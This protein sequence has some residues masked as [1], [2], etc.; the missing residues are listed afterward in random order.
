M[1]DFDI[2]MDKADEVEIAFYDQQ[3][4]Q[5][6]P[7]PRVLIGV[8]WLKVSDLLEAL[9]RQK[10]EGLD[11]DA[12]GW[13]TAAT[14]RGQDGSSGS[15]GQRRNGDVDAPLGQHG[16]LKSG[17]HMGGGP[18]SS[19]HGGPSDGLDGWFNVEPQGAV[20]FHLDFGTSTWL[21]HSRLALADGLSPC[22][23]QSRRTSAVVRS[24]LPEGSVDRALS[25]SARARC[26]R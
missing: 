2:E 18:S 26:T 11:G 8:M 12:A 19:G 16:G 25:R 9:R 17:G 6:N 4:G 7:P 20:N 22:R 3:G 23:L 10:V 5:K 1:Q 21:I 13:V 24:M 15:S 14:V